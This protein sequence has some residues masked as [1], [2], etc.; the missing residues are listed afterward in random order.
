MFTCPYC[1]EKTEVPG[2]ANF[3]MVDAANAACEHCGRDFVIVDNLAMTEEQYRAA[4]P[5]GRPLRTQRWER[6]SGSA[7]QS[8]DPQG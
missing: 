8:P 6:A 4:S 3:W 5:H 7:D 1:K 2:A